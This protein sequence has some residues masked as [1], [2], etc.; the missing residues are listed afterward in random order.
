[1]QCSSGLH[2]QGKVVIICPPTL[3]FAHDEE[4]LEGLYGASY[5]DPKGS[6]RLIFFPAIHSLHLSRLPRSYV[7]WYTC[8]SLSVPSVGKY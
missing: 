7:K 4:L 3:P 8:I 2:L 1:M 6:S 5:I